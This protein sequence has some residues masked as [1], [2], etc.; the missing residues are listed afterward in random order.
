MDFSNLELADSQSGEDSSV[1]ESPRA[2]NLID[3]VTDSSTDSL[4]SKEYGFSTDVSSTRKRL[5]R[6]PKGASPVAA[7]SSW[8]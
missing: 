4:D 1:I 6:R 3:Y 7:S 8:Q 5:R 2:D